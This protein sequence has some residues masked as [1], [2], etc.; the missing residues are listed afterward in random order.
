[1]CLGVPG[2]VVAVQDR[3][4]ATVSVAGVER[5]ISI[6]LLADEGVG[7]GDWVLVHVG[8]AL[9]KIDEAE[10]KATLDQIEKLGQA[11]HDEFAAYKQSSIT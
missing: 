3:D 1:M 2:E 5:Q 10:A 7:V 9:S 4:V 11:W 8:F 6:S